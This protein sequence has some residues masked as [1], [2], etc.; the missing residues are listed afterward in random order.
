MKLKK[1]ASLALAGIMAVS[2]LA[3]CNGGSSSSNPTDPETPATGIVAV[4]NE[5]QD[6]NNDVKINFTSNSSLDTMLSSAV[7][8]YGENVNAVAL[9]NRMADLTGLNKTM[10]DLQHYTGMQADGYAHATNKVMDGV[11][12]DVNERIDAFII[13]DAL[14]EDVAMKEAAEMI[15]SVITNM[16]ATSYQKD[17]T[18]A[19]QDYC[20]YSYT[21]SVS[22]VSL[23]KANGNT[24]YCFAYTVAQTISVKTLEA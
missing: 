2:M 11:D 17:H 10:S 5:G 13:A 3:G 15:N 21:G 6:K 4:V 20:D 24:I 1:I 8:A 18:I 19:G 23:T 14:N 9:L 22:M 12:G 16:K 7:S